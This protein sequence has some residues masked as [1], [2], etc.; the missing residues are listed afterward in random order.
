VVND[1]DVDD[2]HCYIV[3]DGD[4]CHHCDVDVVVHRIDEWTSWDGVVSP[5]V[6]EMIHLMC[7]HCPPIFQLQCLIEF[8][9]F[10]VLKTLS[11]F[12]ILFTILHYC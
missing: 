8:A 10:Y 3:R 9:R 5:R 11:L 7:S 2:V 1:R 12:I 6:R 4:L